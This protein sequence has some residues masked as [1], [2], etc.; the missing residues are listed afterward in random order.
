MGTLALGCFIA[1][2]QGFGGN[3]VRDMGIAASALAGYQLGFAGKI[4]G[5]DDEVG[6]LASQI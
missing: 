6:T 2:R 1:R 4:A 3:L 5:E